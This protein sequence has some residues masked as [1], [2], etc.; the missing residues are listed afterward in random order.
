[1]TFIFLGYPFLVVYS[2][3]TSC[4][5]FY[6]GD[7]EIII[8]PFSFKMLRPKLAASWLVM[9]VCL[10]LVAI[11]KPLWAKYAAASI[12]AL[13]MAILAFFIL[14]A[15]FIEIKKLR[16]KWRELNKNQ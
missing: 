15:Q 8:K 14:K 16:K 11:T 5:F 9:A 1:M 12:L 2:L 4:F 10:L 6:L 7:T 3:I 13:D